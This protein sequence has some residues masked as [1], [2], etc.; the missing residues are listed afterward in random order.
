MYFMTH[1]STILFLISLFSLGNC[2]R[3][4]MQPNSHKC[5]REELRQNVLVKGVY[6]VIPADGQQIDYVVCLFFILVF[7]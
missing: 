6:E 1:W 7:T 3:W 5:L 4:Y 2:V